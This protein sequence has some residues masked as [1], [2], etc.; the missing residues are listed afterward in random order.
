MTIWLVCDPAAGFRRFFAKCDMMKPNA[1]GASRPTFSWTHHHSGALARAEE[2][3]ARR[4]LA[5]VPGFSTRDGERSAAD[6]ARR[7]DQPR[8]PGRCRR[9][10]RL[11]AHSRRRGRG[12]DRPARRG[13][14]CP[15]CGEGRRRAGGSVFR[16]G[17]RDAHAF[18]RGCGA[19]PAGANSREAKARSSAGRW[20]FG[21]CTSA[22]VVFAGTFRAFATI[23]ALCRARFSGLEHRSSDA[24]QAAIRA[25]QAIG[26]RARGASCRAKALP[27]R[28]DRAEPARYRRTGLAGRLGIF[29]HERPDVG[30]RLFLDRI[31]ARRGRRPRAARAPISG[32]RPRRRRW[33]AHGG[34]EAGLRG[35]GGALGADP[36]GGGQSGRRFFRTMRRRRSRAPRSGCGA[37]EFAEHVE[38]LRRGLRQARVGRDRLTPALP[39]P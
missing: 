23:E 37:A 5:K 20:R 31:A 34:L 29:R 25:M 11:P 14:E 26:R 18:R 10:E 35:A 7:H 2:D 32:A 30:P 24:E 38:A 13:G 1:F 15:A 28:S 4:R 8:L 16:R 6:A 21:G 39:L 9:A 27:L 3:D 19:A 12:D 33:R 22:D 17:R 36:G